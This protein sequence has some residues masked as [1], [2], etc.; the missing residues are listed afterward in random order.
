MAF[1]MIVIHIQALYGLY[2]VL[3][4]GNY[5]YWVLVRDISG[6]TQSRGPLIQFYSQSIVEIIDR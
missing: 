4:H 5:V 2:S 6:T 1:V 3:Y